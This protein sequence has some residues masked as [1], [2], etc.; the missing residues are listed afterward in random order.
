LCGGAAP[1]L[2]LLGLGLDDYLH[3]TT[4]LCGL[5]VAA[6]P[7]GADE[8]SAQGLMASVPGVRVEQFRCLDARLVIVHDDGG[9]RRRGRHNAAL[10]NSFLGAAEPAQKHTARAARL[11]GRGA[12]TRRAVI[13][14]GGSFLQFCAFLSSVLGAH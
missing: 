10:P 3:C 9:G 13:W 14:E 12:G 11:F 2:R 4:A 5:H 6:C 8:N 7:F 1:G